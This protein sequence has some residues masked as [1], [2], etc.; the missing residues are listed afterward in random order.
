VNTIA[1][2]QDPHFAL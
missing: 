2:L 1:M